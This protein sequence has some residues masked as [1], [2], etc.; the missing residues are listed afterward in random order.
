MILLY[1]LILKVIIKI[2][3]KSK[4]NMLR[5]LKKYDKYKLYRS[6]ASYNG[7]LRIGNNNLRYIIN[8]MLISYFKN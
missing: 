8:N 1:Y 4:V 3:N 5:N 6:I 2:N 7:I